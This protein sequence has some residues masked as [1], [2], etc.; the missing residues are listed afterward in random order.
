MIVFCILA[1]DICGIK[2]NKFLSRPSQ[3]H[4]QVSG[5]SVE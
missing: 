3:C 2:E 1:T 5:K 4:L